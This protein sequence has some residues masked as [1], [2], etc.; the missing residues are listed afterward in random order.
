MDIKNQLNGV[1]DQLA[2]QVQKQVEEELVA[3]VRQQ[4][5]TIDFVKLV[6][7][8][9]NIH[10]D[11]KLAKLNF[12]DESIPASA[13]R[14]T[15]AALS[16]D[17]IT[18]GIIKNFSSTGIDDR[19]TECQVTILDNQVVIEQPVVTSA[20]IVRGPVT[21]EGNL[22]LDGKLNTDSPGFKNIVEASATA[23]KQSLDTALFDQYSD[24]VTTKLKQ[25]GIDAGSVRINDRPVITDGELA[26][27]IVKSNL[28]RVGELTELQVRGESLLD[29]TMFVAGKRVGINT[30]EPGGALAVWDEE[31]ELV[32]RKKSANTGYLGSTRDVSFIIG[33]NNKENICIDPDGSVTIADLRLGAIPISTASVEP[34]WQ[35]RAGEIVFNDS[36]VIGK[37]IGWVCLEG[38][39]WANFGTIQE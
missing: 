10:L 3:Y 24:A 9:V 6:K 20:A 14:F 4:V 19:A 22:T 11:S 35:G 2:T 16:G 37:P 28:R 29:N 15:E 33:S 34:T 32:V 5:A 27:T 39:R 13:I 36:P 30:L 26:P 31:V 23:V 1:F 8:Q 38:H 12:P 7:D 21:I 17:C 18:G 25:S